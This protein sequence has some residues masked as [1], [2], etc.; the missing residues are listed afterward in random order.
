MYNVLKSMY[1]GSY[2]RVKCKGVLTEPISIKQ[3]VHQESVLSPLLFNIFINDIGDNLLLDGA[4]ILHESR[5]SH[6]LY[7][8]DLV[9]FSTSENELQNN[10]DR[11]NTFCKNWGLAIN[12]NKSKI[13]VFSKSGGVEKDAFRFNLSG[14]EIE[15]VKQYKYLGVNFTNT[16]KFAVAEKTLSLKANRALFSIKQSIFDKSLKPSVIL[17]IFE[18]LVKPIALYGSEIWVPYKTCYKSK[19]LDEMFEMSF[20]SN[21]DFDK[22][23]IKFCKY[24]LG[25][26]S[27]ASNFAVLSELGRLPLLLSTISSCVNFWL[28]I[29]QSDSETLLSKAYIEQYNSSS[30]K[31]LWIQFIKNILCDLGFS[32]VW[33]NQSTFNPVALLA[34]IKNKLKERFVSF[35]KQRMLG[36]KTNKKLRTYKL[37]KQNFGIETYLEIIDDKM[38]RKCL[39]SFRISAHKLR[40]ERGRYVRPREDLEKRLC[41]IC[42]TIEDEIHFICKCKKYENERTFLYDN[43]SDM[44]IISTEDHKKTFLNLLTNSNKYVLHAVGKYIQDCNVT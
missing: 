11:V 10:I 29:L 39:S 32:H 6:L 38:I 35:R 12:I 17:N 25:V 14:E 2:S 15:Y 37:L 27:K 19:T 5:I 21:C 18:S 9:L 43:L 40:I 13:M 24:I 4:P 26:H 20:K 44:Q 34:S 3:G 30:D 41:L 23:H 22:I 1:R 28:H 36:D 16:G 7:A 31:R 42:N 33:N 8:D